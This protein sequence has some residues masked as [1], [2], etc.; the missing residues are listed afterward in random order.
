MLNPGS[1]LRED[2]DRIARADPHAWNHNTQYHAFLP[3]RLPARCRAALDIGCGTGAFPRLLAAPA[4]AVPR[5]AHPGRFRGTR[6]VCEARARHGRRGQYVTLPEIRRI[7]AKA[8]PGAPIRRHLLWRYPIVWRK[9]MEAGR[10]PGSAR[11][12]GRR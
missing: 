12:N 4:A 2:F 1:I 6:E 5:L 8:L 11:G 10:D 7:C 9:R 3:H